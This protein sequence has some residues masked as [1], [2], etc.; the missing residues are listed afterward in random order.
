MFTESD[1]NPETVK[2]IITLATPHTPVLLLDTYLNEYY[3]KVNNFWDNN[4]PSNMSVVSVGGGPRDLLVKS[5]A[6]STSH[7]SINVIVSH[8]LVVSNC[9]LLYLNLMSRFLST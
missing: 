6:T 9:A 5:S 7:A 4:P 8:V 1:F 2:V 3:A